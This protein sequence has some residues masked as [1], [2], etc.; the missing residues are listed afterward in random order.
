MPVYVVGPRERG[1][2]P[3]GVK[4]I[5][6]VSHSKT[7]SQGLSPF[8]LGPVKLYGDYV[9]KNMENGWQYAKV[10]PQFLGPDGNPLEDYFIWAQGGWENPKAVRY[11]MGKMGKPAYSW[12]DG[13]KLSY[14][15]ARKRIYAPLYSEA[16]EKTEAYRRLRQIYEEQGEVWLWD[17][18]GYNHRGLGM[19]Y[20]E[21]LN[22]ETRKMG[23]AFVLAMM[24]EGERVW[25]A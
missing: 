16:V 14:V 19:S 25:E 18:D 3:E 5:S 10:Y 15:Q 20:E 11:P 8:I 1:K 6:T 13:E 17:F 22:C 9:A 4:T 21:V 23:H 2:L 12:W 24:L 7:W